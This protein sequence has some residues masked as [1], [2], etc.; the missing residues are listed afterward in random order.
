MSL[1]LP[2]TV[3]LYVLCHK[4]DSSPAESCFLGIT[5]KDGK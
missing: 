1:V 2:G 3:G 4:G 5:I